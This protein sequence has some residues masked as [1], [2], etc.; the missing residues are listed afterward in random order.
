MKYTVTLCISL[1][2]LSLFQ[3]CD[4]V[5]GLN[6]K[7]EIVETEVWLE[8]FDAIRVDTQIQL[9]IEQNTEQVAKISGL[10]FMVSKLKFTVQNKLLI[11][12]SNENAHSRIDQNATV[13]LPIN[14][15]NE[16][17]INAPTNLRS[18][19][20]L[21]LE[22]FRLII[23]G[24]GTYSE[25][26]LKLNCQSLAIAAFGENSGDHILEGQTENL[27]ITMEGLA[28]TDASNMKA[29]QVSIN[30]R[31]LK[32]IYVQAKNQL[33]VNM[34]S[35]GNVYYTGQPLLS[36]QVFK[37]DWDIVFGMAI[38]NSQ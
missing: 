11:I 5:E 35:S 12:E 37:A 20:A 31:S 14:S 28:W 34:Y 27:Y 21:S 16:I 19:G 17:M 7:G 24:P 1:L 23:N 9:V 4:Y 38:N 10:D 6:R 30:Q 3:N 15:L 33:T 29:S 18:E 32:N 13:Y 8:D 36:Y 25:S 2:F 26:N 22:Y